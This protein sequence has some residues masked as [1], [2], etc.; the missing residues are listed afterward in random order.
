MGAIGSLIPPPVARNVV[1]GKIS[2]RLG[3]FGIS[4]N[5]HHPLLFP[6]YD[7]YGWSSLLARIYFG[8]GSS[9]FVSYLVK[10]IGLVP[11]T[12]VIKIIR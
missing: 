3:A 4:T 9:L 1:I 6:Q 2:V 12:N 5:L 10:Y 11:R 7:H 8:H